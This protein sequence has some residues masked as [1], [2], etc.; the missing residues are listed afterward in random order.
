MNKPIYNFFTSDH[1]R[2]EQILLEAIADIDNINLDLYETFRVGLMTHIKM[3]EKVLFLAAQ[4]AN[5]G[6]PLP[7]AAQLRLEHGA[8]TTLL[9]VPPNPTLIKVLV[10]ILHKH[11]FREE[12]PGG[13]YDACEALTADQ[14][15][16][17]LQR[18][19]AVTD[20][21]TR[22]LNPLPMV[23]ETAIRTVQRAGYDYD[24]IAGMTIDPKVLL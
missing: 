1:R 20:V 19:R 17:L 11:D 7:I 9:S 18:L 16:E 12:E 4:E 8:I 23:F 13:M 3:E 15:D 6:E 21:P 10:Y 22:S 2:V 14:T 5:N 24:E